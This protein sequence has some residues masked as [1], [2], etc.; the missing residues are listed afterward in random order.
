MTE[1]DELRSWMVNNLFI[2]PSSL[3]DHTVLKSDTNGKNAPRNCMFSIFYHCYNT[4]L[5]Q[6]IIQL[7]D[8]ASPPFYHVGEDTVKYSITFLGH[9][10]S[11]VGSGVSV[12]WPRPSPQIMSTR[13]LRG[14]ARPPSPLWASPPFYH[15]EEDTDLGHR[16][17]WGGGSGLSDSSPRPPLWTTS[18]WWLRGRW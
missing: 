16:P 5:F 11:W 2:C 7:G 13:W 12:I 1:L 8:T 9:C 4:W 6:S 15:L 14:G 18:T 17:S 3:K 10:P